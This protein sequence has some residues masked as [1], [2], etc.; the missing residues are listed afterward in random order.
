MPRLYKQARPGSDYIHS[1]QLLKEFKRR[2]S[3]IPTKS[4]LMLGL[5]NQRRNYSNIER[6]SYNVEMLTLGQYLQPSKFICLLTLYNASRISNICKIAK[7]WDL[8]CC[9]WSFSE[10]ILSCR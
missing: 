2:F 4:G 9:E 7:N 8:P 3:H 6:S 10:I 1:L 5:V